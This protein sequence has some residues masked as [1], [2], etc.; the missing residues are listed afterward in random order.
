MQVYLVKYREGLFGYNEA[1]KPKVFFKKEDAEKDVKH[2]EA[3]YI[4]NEH[5]GYASITIIE[6]V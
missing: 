1:Q 5:A 6:A 4:G 3:T 2:F